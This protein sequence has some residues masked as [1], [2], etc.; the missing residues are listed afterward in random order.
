MCRYV[1][2]IL[3]SFILIFASTFFGSHEMLSAREYTKEHPMII[4]GSSTI[5]PISYIDEKGVPAGLNIEVLKNVA[6]KANI[7]YIIEMK[8]WEDFINDIKERKCDLACM[9]YNDQFRK[10]LNTNFGSCSVGYLYQYVA[11]RRGESHIHSLNDLQNQSVAV[12]KNSVS[13]LMLKVE[14]KESN[15]VV[16]P[17]IQEALVD[18]SDGK[19]NMLIWNQ[20]SLKYLI[21]KEGLN[22]LA[23]SDLG[24]A[25]DEYRFISNSPAL[26]KTIDGAYMELRKQ[27]TL[28]TIYSKWKLDDVEESQYTPVFIY[29]VLGIFVFVILLFCLFAVELRRRV[30]KLNRQLIFKNMTV[31]LALRV[32]KMKIGMYN[33]K[34]NR[35]YDIEGD[36]LRKKEIDYNLYLR[37]FCNDDAQKFDKIINELK[38]GKTKESKSV[39]CIKDDNDNDRHYIETVLIVDEVN[40][41]IVETI[42]ILNKD[43]TDKL[44]TKKLLEE[45]VVNMKSA[46]ADLQK[47]HSQINYVLESNKIRIWRYDI[48]TQKFTVTTSTKNS[49]FEL[50]AQEYID[51]HS[52]KEKAIAIE[53]IS[54]ANEG[55]LSSFSFRSLHIKTHD[56]GV[57]NCYFEFNGVPTKNENGEVVSYFGLLRDLTELYN[58][59]NKLKEETVKAKDSEKMKSAFLANISH[60]IRT[61]LNAIMGFSDLYS[62]SDNA[63]ERDEYARIIRINS[64][65]LMRLISDLLEL[66]SIES[67]IIKF[68][69]QKIDLAV[70]FTDTCKTVRSRLDYNVELKVINPYRNC[71]V[72]IDY[73]RMA[74][75]LINFINNASKY[76]HTGYIEAQYKYENNGVLIKV[77]DTGCGIPK[78]KCSVIFDRFVKL[79]T[80]VQGTGLGLSICKAIAEGMNGKI[81]CESIV[82][83]GSTFWTWLPCDAEVI[84]M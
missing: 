34:K 6:E 18:L 23:I 26:L 17:N 19:Y 42:I 55:I 61:P 33:L 67:K 48:H 22:N 80:F 76:T 21:N 60:E 78:E 1:K 10:L 38:C 50:S 32:G 84:N 65:M 4:E 81:G 20:M 27:G 58:I 49:T 30:K 66:S 46:M 68:Y 13:Y 16:V 41:G 12:E 70:A 7:P 47:F 29:F 5:C 39:F 8:K 28:D 57:G 59:Q 56:R 54:R 31:S 75:I 77:K 63:T 40:D 11:Y 3:V 52:D 44:T 15:I 43:I 9:L 64:Q 24:I 72:T 62:I 37:S 73:S 79:N 45:S 25:P 53:G 35:I 2:H 51:E 83:K 36:T 69:P 71:V 14:N 74:E 82:G